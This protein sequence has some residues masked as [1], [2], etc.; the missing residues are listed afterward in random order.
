[1]DMAF[2]GQ[3]APLASAFHEYQFKNDDNSI[4]ILNIGGFANLTFL[5]SNKN[6]II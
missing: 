6:E 2:G 4:V 1:M 3:G 5:P